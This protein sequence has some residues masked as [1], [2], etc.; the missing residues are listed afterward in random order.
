[1]RDI[2][3]RTIP[4]DMGSFAESGCCIH[5]GGCDWWLRRVLQAMS[6][7]TTVDSVT[8]LRLISRLASPY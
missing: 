3:L 7:L 8:D 4:A 6:S 1:M 5:Q 2:H